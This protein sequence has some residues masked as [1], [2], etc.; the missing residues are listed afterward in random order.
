[1]KKMFATCAALCMVLAAPALADGINASG[2]SGFVKEFSLSGGTYD[3]YI[4]A[5]FVPDPNDAARNDCLF[6]GRF[7]RLNV[8]SDSARIGTDVRISFVPYKVF[9]TVTLPAGRYRLMVTPLSDCDWVFIISPPA[10]S[11]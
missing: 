6:L 11:Q 9:K 4:R 8:D 5:R 10:A 2:S 3:V 1:M 7:S